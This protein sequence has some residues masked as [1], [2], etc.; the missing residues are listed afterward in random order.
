MIT[1]EKINRELKEKLEAEDELIHLKQSYFDI[2]NSVSE[3]IYILDKNWVFLEVNK[4][5][6]RMYGYTKEELEGKTPADVSVSGK[7]NL[8]DIRIHCLLKKI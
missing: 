6:E 2:F 4:G 7:N 8:T 1:I 5:A 3:A